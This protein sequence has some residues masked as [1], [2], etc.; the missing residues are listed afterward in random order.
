MSGGCL[1]RKLALG[2]SCKAERECALPSDSGVRCATPVG[3]A[4]GLGKCV[5]VPA[6]VRGKSEDLCIETCTD[7]PGSTSCAA[8]GSPSTGAGG[9][10]GPASSSCFTNDGLYCASTSKCSPL[11]AVNA[12]CPQGYCATRAYCSAGTCEP[13]LAAGACASDEACMTSARCDQASSK[14][15]PKF[16]DGV[17]CTAASDCLNT[18]CNNGHCGTPTAASSRTCAGVLD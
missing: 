16:G 9:G 15:T 18:G 5:A 4:G 6:A 1:S 2:A 10:Q 11:P 14:C 7:T 12:P 8:S 3:T 13:Q 17:V